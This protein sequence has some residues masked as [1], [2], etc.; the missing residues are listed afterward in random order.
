[1]KCSACGRKVIP[2]ITPQG[3]KILMDADTS[4]FHDCGEEENG[5]MA[6]MKDDLCYVPHINVC[7]GKK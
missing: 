5:T 7:K 4:T 1:M 6:V 2:A 3:M